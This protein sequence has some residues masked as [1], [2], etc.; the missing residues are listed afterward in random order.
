MIAASRGNQRG[1]DGRRDRAAEKSGK[2]VDRKRAAHARFIHVRGQDRIIG[3][4]I[5][6]VGKS[7]QHGARDQPGIA[8]MDAEH[9]KGEASG[10]E[11]DQQDLAGADAVGEVAYRR[12]G[13]AGDNG[14]HGERKAELDVTD[15]ELLLEKREQHRQH[16]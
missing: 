1:H 10:G 9:H 12:L 2:S 16:K 15:P 11:A 3:G 5:D 8:Q 13:Q 14:E 4:M 6:A 7:E